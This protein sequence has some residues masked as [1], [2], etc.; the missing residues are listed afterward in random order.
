MVL[1][2]LFRRK[3]TG[4]PGNRGL[5]ASRQRTPDTI[6]LGPTDRRAA[7]LQQIQASALHR[8]NQL[9]DYA[10]TAQTVDAYEVQTG[11]MIHDSDGYP[12]GY[13]RD[14]WSL[15]NGERNVEI[16]G[17]FESEILRPLSTVIVSRP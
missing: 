16:E 2:T 12:I 17:S 9:T 14:I 3:N 7:N 13:A 11:D 8:A 15:E 1:K 5:F 6:R 10:L 4:Q